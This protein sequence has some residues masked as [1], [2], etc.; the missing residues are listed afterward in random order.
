MSTDKLATCRETQET[1]TKPRTTMAPAVDIFEAGEHYI[2]EA[3]L[4]GVQRDSIAVD[5]E[6]RVLT[7]S[8]DRLQTVP[9]N[10]RHIAGPGYADG[11]FR[12]L[13]LGEDINTDAIEAH[14]AEGVLKVTM[15][16]SVTARK[17]AIEINPAD[18]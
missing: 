18:T 16:K 8:A 15:P 12:R 10:A 11:Y 17:R 3:Y 4:P 9:D 1:Q 7:L 6:Q 2:L 14:Y 5:V 13:R